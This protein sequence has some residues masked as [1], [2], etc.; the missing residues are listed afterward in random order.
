ME[1]PLK[2]GRLASDDANV[3]SLVE[4][5]ETDA[6]KMLCESMVIDRRNDFINYYTTL[7][8]THMDRV[9]IGQTLSGSHNVVNLNTGTVINT[10]ERRQALSSFSHDSQLWCAIDPLSQSL[11]LRDWAIPR[12]LIFHEFQDHLVLSTAL[13]QDYIAIIYTKLPPAKRAKSSGK[14]S[15]KTCLSRATSDHDIQANDPESEVKTFADHGDNM[16]DGAIGDLRDSD[17]DTAQIPEKDVD[18]G[19]L[20][21]SLSQLNVISN[22]AGDLTSVEL[23]DDSDDSESSEHLKNYTS[24]SLA[25]DRDYML[26]CRNTLD[27]KLSTR[28][29]GG[30]PVATSMDGTSSKGEVSSLSDQHRLVSTVPLSINQS[31]LLSQSAT[32]SFLDREEV[33]TPVDQ[34]TPNKSIEP[35]FTVNIYRINKS[36]H[37]NTF[38]APYSLDRV[39][40]QRLRGSVVLGSYFETDQTRLYIVMPNYEMYI[41]DLITYETEFVKT[42]AYPQRFGLGHA[43]GEYRFTISSTG[44]NLKLSTPIST[45]GQYILTSNKECS[46]VYRNEKVYIEGLPPAAC[47]S[48]KKPVVWFYISGRFCELNLLKVKRNQRTLILKTNA[49]GQMPTNSKISKPAIAYKV[50]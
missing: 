44:K 29:Q 34:L 7:F 32:L 40:S 1:S 10:F 8:P 18:P 50:K 19:F 43:G 26:S 48:P 31:P 42:T 12:L 47:L 16:D 14:A 24:M 27:S 49:R 33:R 37:G 20:S 22:T 28:K 23:N 9:I 3:F 2:T 30:S 17:L 46:T 25:R 6:V 4:L 45:Y 41:M 13:M 15:S 35:E 36:V 21:R 39:V 38:T 11:Y 5:L